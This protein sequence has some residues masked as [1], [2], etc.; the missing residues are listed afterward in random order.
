MGFSA[1]FLWGASCAAYQVEGGFDAD[2]KGM[3][4]WDEA[5]RDKSFAAHGET[6][7]VACDFY[8]KMRSDVELMAKMGLKAFRFSISWSRVIP[9]GTGKINE[10]G[11]RFYSDLVDELKKHNIEPL[12][13]LYHWDLPLALE[14]R[15]GWEN[16]EIEDWFAEYVK[17]VCDALSDR[18]RYWMTINEP[19][20]FVGVGYFVGGHPP[21]KR[22]D[23]AEQINVTKNILRSHGRAVRVLREYAKLPP[24]IGLA[25]TGDVY[26][27]KTD[28][29]ENVKIARDRSFE[30]DKYGFTMQNS[31]WGDPIFLGR[32]PEGA[33]KTYPEEM[34]IFTAED[35]ELI[36][37]PLD[38]Y[39]FNA[40]KGTTPHD[41]P[42]ES[43]GEY[44]YQGSP[45]TMSGWEVTPEVMYWSPKFLYERYKKPI[46]VT[47]NG[48]AGMDWVS[49]GGG[50][51]DKQREDF[52]HRYILELRRA[53]DDGVPVIGY[54]VWSVMDNMEWNQGYDIRFGLI[55]VDYRT[56][57][58]TIKDSGYWYRRVIETNGGEL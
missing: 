7:N 24:I 12:V 29:P 27:P 52:L 38:F 15:G 48:M 20:M 43:Y 57:E 45:R 55:Y 30:F 8:H 58:R 41:T 3:S 21:F 47:E 50:V 28:D 14:K 22:L 44:A 42:R 39:G 34:A 4:I 35:M 11:L 23:A 1:D 17:V 51:H 31:W 33:Y 16:P 13:T 37:S 40:Y 6:G 46:M 54:N 36:S 53:V 32:F 10:A 49:L 9:E 2:G 19:Q 56:M 18:V 25:P 5:V 26:L